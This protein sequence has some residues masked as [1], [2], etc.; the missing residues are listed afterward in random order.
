[1]SSSA[2]DKLSPQQRLFCQEYIVDSNA[3]K[4]YLAAGYKAKSRSIADSSASKLL[5]LPKIQAYIAELLENKRKASEVTAER[6]VKELAAIAFHRSKKTTTIKDGIATVI[7]SDDWDEESSA[8]VQEISGEA[9]QI[10]GDDSSLVAKR[11]KVKTYDKVRALELLSKI[12]GLTSDLPM[13]IATLK[14]YGIVLKR[15]PETN[16]FYVE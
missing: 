3:Y 4:A 13:A 5:R 2:A 10:M 12:N 7:D 9:T 15:D 14:N 11:L 6:I 1:V 8:A 16:R